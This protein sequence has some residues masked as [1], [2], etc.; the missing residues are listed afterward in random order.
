[1]WTRGRKPDILNDLNVPFRQQKASE[2]DLAQIH[3]SW[4]LGRRQWW[5]VQDP[6]CLPAI[7]FGFVRR[8]VCVHARLYNK[9]GKE[10]PTSSLRV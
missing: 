5:E 8:H 2:S 4:L 9:L 6:R 7:Y 10:A 3:D 1:M